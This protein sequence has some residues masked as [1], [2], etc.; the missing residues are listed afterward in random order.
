MNGGGGGD[1][2]PV[3]WDPGDGFPPGGGNN[4]NSCPLGKV[5]DANT[6]KCVCP[7]GYVEDVNGN[8]VKKPCDKDPVAN[9]ELAPQYG[10]SKTKGA[11]FGC[12]RYGGTC[13]GDNGRNKFHAGID[14]KNDYGKP[15][16]A[17]Y[18]GFIYSTKHDSDGAGY[19]TR[20]QSTVNGET[21]ITEFFHLQK[22][23]RILQNL[24]G[25]PLVKVKAGDIIGYQGNSGNLKDA[26]EKGT[27]DSHLHI[28]V[29]LHNGSTKWGYANFD[30]VDPRD[31]LKTVIKD[32]GTSENNTNCN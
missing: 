1:P 11:L 19:Y 4:N 12:T 3:L 2:N 21:Y 15:V 9:I 26:I 24:P 30:T 18:D 31:Y 8:C 23:N 6:G 14:I 28:E 32:D 25:Q 22:D 20:I 13:I 16:Y 17:M 27:V 7:E 5:K 29:R 10:K